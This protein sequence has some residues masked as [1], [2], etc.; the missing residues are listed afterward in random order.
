MKMLLKDGKNRV[1]T[2]SYDDGV[3]YDEK[4]IRILDKYGLKCTFNINTSHTG[5]DGFHLSQDERIELYRNSGHEVAVHGYTHPSFVDINS[6]EL[7]REVIL[8]RENIERDFGV[9]A[10]G[11]AYPFGAYNDDVI[12]ILKQCG[13]VYAR[14][15]NSTRG[16]GF[17]ANWLEL[18]PT[19][20]HKDGR[21]MELA[22]DFVENEEA[23][24]RNSRMFYLWGHSY[25]F[26]WDNNWNIIEEFAEYI[27]GRDNIWYAT[28]IDVYNYVTAYRRLE[29]SYDDRI[30]YNPSAIDVWIEVNGE[31]RCIKG[32]ETVIF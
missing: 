17:P 20:H 25:E 16:F 31:I 21:L 5:G 10:N 27:G 30:V 14:T 6:Q 1:V 28:N 29:R 8:D 7:I 24:K 26:D 22:R 13:I 19:A 32:G 12:D 18:N 2:L 3:V 4:L 9:I 23:A 11:L 15:V